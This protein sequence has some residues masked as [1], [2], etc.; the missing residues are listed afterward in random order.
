LVFKRVGEGSNIKKGY[1]WGIKFPSVI[2]G[3][4]GEGG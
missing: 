1:I 4:N 3:E 2:D